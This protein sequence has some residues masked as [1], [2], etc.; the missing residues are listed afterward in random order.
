APPPGLVQR[1]TDMSVDDLDRIPR[2]RPTRRAVVR[3]AAAGIGLAVAAV[4]AVRA[5]LPPDPPIVA[6]RRQAA[7]LGCVNTA[8][9]FRAA[10]DAGGEGSTTIFECFVDDPSLGP[11]CDALAALYARSAKGLEPFDVRVGS[12]DP[13]AGWARGSRCWR[14]YDGQGHRSDAPIP[15]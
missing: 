4:F 8:L 15:L 14:H 5:C 2:N 13:R 10:A 7:E 3:Y 11:D 9:G 6:L 1:P 12:S